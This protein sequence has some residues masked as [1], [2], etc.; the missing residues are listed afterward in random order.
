LRLSDD[1]ITHLT[2][3]LLKGLLDRDI[4]DITEEE[5]VVRRTIKR[6]IIAQLQIGEDID[7]VATDKIQSLS[8]N[9][10]EGSPEWEVLYQKFLNEEERKR[11]LAD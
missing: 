2:H 5:G 4:V 10:V 8:R 11:G 1:K 9:V 3:V 6:V 7:K